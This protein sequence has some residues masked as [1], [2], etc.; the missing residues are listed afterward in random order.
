MTGQHRFDKYVRSIRNED[1]RKY[2]AAY[3]G[4]IRGQNHQPWHINYCL[5]VM[6]AQAVRLRLDEIDRD[7]WSLYPASR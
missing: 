4:Y 7:Y 5:T 3:A 1:K 2:A 6:G